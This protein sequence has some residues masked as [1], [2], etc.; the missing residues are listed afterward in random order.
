MVTMTFAGLYS[1]DINWLACGDMHIKVQ[2]FYLTIVIKVSI[3]EKVVFSPL[4][5]W[6]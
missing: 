2:G 1:W 4:K 5:V 6:K 3:N